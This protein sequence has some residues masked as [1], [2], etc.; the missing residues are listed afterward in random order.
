[1]K[2]PQRSLRQVMHGRYCTKDLVV[3]KSQINDTVILS[4]M[5][6]E[7]DRDFVNVSDRDLV[8]YDLLRPFT[9]PNRSPSLTVHR[10]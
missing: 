10:P 8:Q 9:V 7:R 6:R 2:V 4:F 3:K 5:E 1:M